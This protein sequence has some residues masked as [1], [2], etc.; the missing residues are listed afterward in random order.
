MKDNKMDWR[1]ARKGNPK[2]R[3]LGKEEGATLASVWGLGDWGFRLIP[4]P[5]QDHY[6]VVLGSCEGPLLY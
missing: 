2:R 1:V 4:L 3:S 6:G 5:L